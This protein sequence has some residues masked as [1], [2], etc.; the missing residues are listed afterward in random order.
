VYRRGESVYSHAVNHR[1]STA[2]DWQLRTVESLVKPAAATVQASATVQS[3]LEGLPKWPINR[4]YV[5]EDDHIVAWLDPRDLLEQ[6]QAGRLDGDTRAGAIAHPVLFTLTPEMSLG[7]A[8]EG[9]LREKTTVLPV[10][11]G[12]WGNKL[13]G[14]VLRHD[15]LL[16]IRDRLTFPQ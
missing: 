12:Q 16:A 4:V 8:L 3:L 6:L 15:V 7:T 11:S 5:L 13:L 2:D 10:V 1:G 9:F 14:E